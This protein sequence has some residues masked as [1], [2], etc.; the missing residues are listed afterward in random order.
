MCAAPHQGAEWIKEYVRED[1][2]STYENAEFFQWTKRLWRDPGVQ[3]A[4]KRANEFQINDS[5]K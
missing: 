5:S 2:A 1:D 3:T 4:Y